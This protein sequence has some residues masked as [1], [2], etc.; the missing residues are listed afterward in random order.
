MAPG[1]AWTHLLVLAAWGLG[2]L[3]VAVRFFQ[4][5]PQ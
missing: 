4:W 1:I 5:T 3:V 2:G